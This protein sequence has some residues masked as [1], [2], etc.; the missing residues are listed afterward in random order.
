MGVP[1]ATI[2]S[3]GQRLDPTVELMSVEVRR[4]LN[5]VPE[6]ELTLLDGSVAKRKFEL[7]ESGFF[8]PGKSVRIDLRIE[9]ETTDQRVFEGLVVRHSIETSG[10]GSTLR[11]ELKDAAFKLTRQRKSALFREQADSDAIAKLIRDGGLEAGEIA[12]S[13]VKHAELIQYCASDWDFIVARADVLGLAVDVDAGRVSLRRLA[14][15]ATARTLDYGLDDVAELSLDLDARD[16]W[17][18][19]SS[20]GWDLGNQALGAPQAAAQPAVEIG[21]LDAGAIAAELG[22]AHYTLFH[23]A[24]LEPAELKSWADARLLRS[25]LSL[26]RGRALVAGDA[27]LAPLDTVEINGVGAPFNGKAL[28]SGVVHKVDHAGWQTQLLLGVAPEWFIRQPDIADVRAGGLLPPAAGLQLATVAAFEADPLG[29]HRVKLKLPALDPQSG[30]VWARW[31]RPDAGA[32]RGFLS[33]PEVGD[34]VVVAFLDGDPR[35]PIVLGALHGKSSLAPEYAPTERNDRRSIRSRNA[36]RLEFD[37]ERRSLTLLTPA[38]N[39]IALDDADKTITIED[40]HHNR[41][42][43]SD[44]GIALESARDLVLDAAGDVVIKGAR[45]DIQ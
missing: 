1:V 45:V 36:I 40:Q 29:E 24:A 11:V 19:M 6:A 34:H 7:S 8:A 33:W 16:Q 32:D 12:Q 35:Q 3:E 10:E 4:E 13:S 31:A 21:N 5:R 39:K 44:K 37:D 41:V 14:L 27:R 15:G 17:A 43:L 9:G 42:T 30:F 2:T 25:R 26:L 18:A 28:V 23:P 22:G 20:V 38:G